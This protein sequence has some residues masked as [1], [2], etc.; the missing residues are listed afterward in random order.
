MGGVARIH[1][2]EVLSHLKSTG[3]LDPPDSTLEGV[4]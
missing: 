2:E 3:S 4:G 1:R